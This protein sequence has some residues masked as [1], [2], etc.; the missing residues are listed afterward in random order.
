[1]RFHYSNRNSHHICT[2]E[3]HFRDWKSSL[4]CSDGTKNVITSLQRSYQKWKQS[5]LPTIT[6]A[7]VTINVGKPHAQLPSH[8]TQNTPTQEGSYVDYI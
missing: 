8:Q 5:T 6:L 4:S 7:A 1:M 3:F 2:L